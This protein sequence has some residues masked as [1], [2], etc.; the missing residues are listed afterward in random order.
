MNIGYNDIFYYSCLLLSAAIGM[1]CIK[2]VDTS[3][4]WLAILILLT[5]VSESIAK[6][7][8]FGLGKPNNIV[9]HIFTPIEYTLY[10]IIFSQFLNNKKR[11]ILL[12]L[13]AIGIFLLEIVNSNF[14]QPL[15]MAC[16][17]V[18]MVEGVL[19]VFLSLVLFL[20]IR[21]TPSLGNLLR[22]GVFWFNSAVLCYYAFSTMHWGFHNMEVYNLEDPPLILYDIHKFLSG[23][24][25]LIFS[26]A[27]LLNAV[28]NT[29]VN[30]KI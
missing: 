26:M 27:L 20:K 22:E 30:K 11:E 12:W 5:L 16:T 29:S 23:I 17:N 15:H 8:S 18:I 7:L 19:L 28:A 24:L 1:Y 6:Y 25:Y 3:F 10:V 21:E 2:K 9:Y 13:S 14:F 4:K